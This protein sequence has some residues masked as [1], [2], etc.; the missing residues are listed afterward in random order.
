MRHA[1]NDG[2]R[3]CLLKAGISAWSAAHRNAR[4]IT[5]IARRSANPAVRATSEH[6]RNGWAAGSS[7]GPKGSAAETFPSCRP[8]S[9]C[10]ASTREAQEA[11]REAAGAAWDGSWGLVWCQPNGRPIEQRADWGAWKAL[12]AKAGI[13]A[14]AHRLHDARHTAGTLLGEQHVDIHVI[15]RIL[16]HA[17]LGTTR[18]YTQPTDG[19][20]ADAVQRMGSA[21]WG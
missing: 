2:I 18:R 14:D 10:C 7:P 15:Q 12:L 5:T 1:V 19:L 4:S 8:S 20:T 9:H 3:A 17:Q 6:A 11:E 13:D 21:L 16:G